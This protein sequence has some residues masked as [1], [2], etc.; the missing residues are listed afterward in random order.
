MQ[1]WYRVY[2]TPRL[3]QPQKFSSPLK[4]ECREFR[5][6]EASLKC[7]EQSSAWSRCRMQRERPSES[8]AARWDPGPRALRL[9]VWGQWETEGPDFWALFLFLS[10]KMPLNFHLALKGQWLCSFH[11]FVDT[12]RQWGWRLPEYPSSNQGYLQRGC[13]CCNREDFCPWNANKF[14]SRCCIIASSL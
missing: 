5:G 13:N 10:E 6:E 4:R 1:K 3:E 11:K 2:R 9:A 14:I 12:I 8:L 7:E